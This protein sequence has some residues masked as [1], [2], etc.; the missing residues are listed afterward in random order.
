MLEAPD[1]Y[2]AGASREQSKREIPLPRPANCVFLGAAQD[3]AD[4][5]GYVTFRFCMTWND[6]VDIE[7]C[8]REEPLESHP[9]ELVWFNYFAVFEDNLT[10]P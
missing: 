2:P 6:L 5:L 9:F 4:F 1:L 10:T 3:T 7:Q 8:F